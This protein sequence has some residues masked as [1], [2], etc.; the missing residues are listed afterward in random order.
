ML[1]STLFQHC[2]ETEEKL[3]WAKESFANGHFA[4]AIY[5]SYNVY[6]NGAK[7]MLLKK[8]VIVNTQTGILRD[9]EAHYGN[10][11]VFQHPE[12]FKEF[13]L[14]INKNEPTREFAQRYLNDAERFLEKVQAIRTSKN[15]PNIEVRL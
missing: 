13:V 3:Q 11:E 7:A 5:H 1:L 10:E 6:V 12:G 2:Y 4:D 9:F 8:D 14:Q 15:T